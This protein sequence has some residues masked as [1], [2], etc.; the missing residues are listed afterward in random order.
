VASWSIM[1]LR[2]TLRW[3]GS[4]ELTKDGFAFA[5]F[6]AVL[7]SMGL[8]IISLEPATTWIFYIPRPSA[9]STKAGRIID[10]G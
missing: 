8:P 5:W 7:L 2:D 9:R 10:Y 6:V 1:A 3:N 4:S